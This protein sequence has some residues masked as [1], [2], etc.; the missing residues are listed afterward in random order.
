[1]EFSPRLAR[2]LLSLL[3]SECLML[4]AVTPTLYSTTQSFGGKDQPARSSRGNP[5]VSFP[6]TRDA[7]SATQPI[8]VLAGPKGRVLRLVKASDSSSP[9]TRTGRPKA[10]SVSPRSLPAA[11]VDLP[12]AKPMFA[13]A[14]FVENKGQ[15]DT[16]VKFQLESGGKTLWV[17]DTGIVFDNVRVKAEQ[18]KVGQHSAIQGPSISGR[19]LCHVP[20]C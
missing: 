9:L 7:A 10:S 14:T 3:L 13:A 8:T 11:K 12:V 15:W 17:T 1:V 18:T 16:R 5:L 20:G 19:F 2:S 6:G 4:N